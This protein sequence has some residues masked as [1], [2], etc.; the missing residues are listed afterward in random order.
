MAVPTSVFRTV[1]GFDN[2]FTLAAFEDRELCDGV[3]RCGGRIIS[4]P[5]ALV[6]HSQRMTLR[7]YWRQHFT[8]GRGASTFHKKA[9]GRHAVTATPEPMRFYVNLVRY[10]LSQ[11]KT[12]AALALGG[13]MVLSQAATALGF[14]RERLVALRGASG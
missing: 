10:P 12:S 6:Y 13:L 9:H 3:R 2:G 8:Y 11:R 4:A 7:R 5:E 14:L 1:S